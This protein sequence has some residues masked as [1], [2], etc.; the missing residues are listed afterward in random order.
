MLHEIRKHTWSDEELE[1][2]SSSDD[3]VGLRCRDFDVQVT[4]LNKN[5][6]IALAKHFNLTE[7]DLN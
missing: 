5:D 1:Y 7:K 2:F 6:V 3:Q 4:Y